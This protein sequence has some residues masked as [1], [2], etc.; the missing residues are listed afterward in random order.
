MLRAAAAHRGTA[1]V[2]IY[3]NCNIFNDG[4]FDALKDPDTSDDAIIRLEHGE[5]IRFG[6]DGQPRRG[7]RP[8]SGQA[9]RPSRWPTSHEADLVVHDAH[10]ADPSTAFA[11]SRLTD[12]G[13]LHRAPIG[14]FREVERP[15]YDDL[16]REQIATAAQGQDDPTAALGSLISGS[17]TWTV[18]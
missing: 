5:P 3:Q 13:V 9:V 14:I 12:A 1:L 6:T 2:E 7:P 10:A 11:L 8:D 18:V 17:D 4:A 15:T 16:A